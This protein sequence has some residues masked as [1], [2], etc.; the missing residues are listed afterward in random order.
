MQEPEMINPKFIIMASSESKGEEWVRGYDCIFY[1]SL[2]KF[3]GK[4]I[5][6]FS[7]SMSE[8]FYLFIFF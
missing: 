1:M 4:Y 2:L 8:C 5:D 7:F 6:F 3:V